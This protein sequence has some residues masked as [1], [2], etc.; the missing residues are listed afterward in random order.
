MQSR[1]LSPEGGGGGG[2][3]LE[4]WGGEGYPLES[5]VLDSYS[6]DGELKNGFCTKRCGTVMNYLRRLKCLYNTEKT[7]DDRIIAVFKD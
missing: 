3:P 2:C 1:Q 6:R 4:R 7:D 5:R